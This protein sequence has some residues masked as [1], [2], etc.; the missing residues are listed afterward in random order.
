MLVLPGGRERTEAEYRELY[1]ES[2]V[3]FG[4]RR[5]DA[6]G[7]E[8][9]RRAAGVMTRSRGICFERWRMIQA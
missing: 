9:N 5:A 4:A 2:G 7:S 6:D 1:R 3:P 8:R